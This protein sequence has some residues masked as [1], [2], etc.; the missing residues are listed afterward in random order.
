M[1]KLLI[2]SSIQK[3]LSSLPAKQYKQLSSAIFHLAIDPSP[4]D[5]SLLKG[6]HR[7]ARRLDVGEYRIIYRV[8]G[9]TVEILLVGKRNDN[10]VYKRWGRSGLK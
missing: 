6:T 2:P 8:A 3:N 5:S 4:Q 1:P 9:D 10:E 7:D